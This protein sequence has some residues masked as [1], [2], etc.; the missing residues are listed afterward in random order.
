MYVVT[1]KSY[2]SHLLGSLSTETTYESMIHAGTEMPVFAVAR[3]LLRDGSAVLEVRQ[4][5]TGLLTRRVLRGSDPR[6]VRS[7]T[8]TY[9]L[10]WAIVAPANA[11]ER[12]RF[13]QSVSVALFLCID[14]VPSPKQSLAVWRAVSKSLGVQSMYLSIRRQPFFVN[15]NFPQV[16]PFGAVDVSVAAEEYLAEPQIDC[17][18]NE[19]ELQC[20]SSNGSVSKSPI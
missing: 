11:E 6:Q 10:V 1:D 12:L 16:Y 7:G 9:E 13:K 20:H 3:V 2:I 8:R 4:A 18:I 15:G 5:G 14:E 19:R 17:Y